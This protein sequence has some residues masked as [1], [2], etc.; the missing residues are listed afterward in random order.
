MQKYNPVESIY[1]YIVEFCCVDVEGAV[2][3]LRNNKVFK[4]SVVN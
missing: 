1:M 3:L 4:I 2:I